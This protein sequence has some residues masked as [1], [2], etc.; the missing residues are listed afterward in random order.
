VYGV[1]TNWQVQNAFE[2]FMRER[3]PGVPW[4][5]TEEMTWLEEGDRVK[6]FNDF[7]RANAEMNRTVL[8][9]DRVAEQLLEQPPSRWLDDVDRDSLN[10]SRRVDSVRLGTPYVLAVLRADREYSLNTVGLDYAWRRLA[11]GVMMPT[12][13]Q[14]TIIIGRTGEQPVV[15]QSQD[16]PYRV[17]VKVEPFDF[18]VRMES[19]L[20]TDTIRRAG[21]GH[22]VVNRRH[23]LTLE[24]GIS[25]VALGP[26][27]G[28]FYESGLFA[29]I[30]KHVARPD[31][32]NP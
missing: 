23:V 20:P 29:P 4:F 14:Y 5:V 3:R 31:P 10:F 27:G 22:V 32:L 11:P 9:T 16:R 19:W 8:T 28:P 30:R 12:L 25:F 15:V 26:Q 7:V 6:R 1:D 21:F 24:R 13:R 18:D 17:E 2:Y